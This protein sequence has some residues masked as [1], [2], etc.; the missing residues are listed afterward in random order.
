MN[1]RPTV[2]VQFEAADLRENLR[3]AWD[4][5]RN[6]RAISR[7]RIGWAAWERSSLMSR[8]EPRKT[9]WTPSGEGSTF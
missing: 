1:I 4:L 5:T 8:V 9:A 2:T 3:A 6:S 7:L